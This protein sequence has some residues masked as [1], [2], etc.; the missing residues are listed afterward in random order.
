MLQMDRRIGENIREEAR[1]AKAIAVEMYRAGDLCGA[2]E[3]AVRA[4][5]LNPSLCGLLRLNAVLDVHMGLAKQINGEIDWY[6]VLSVDPTADL[7][8]IQQ[9]YQK[10]SLDIILDDCDNTVCSV[11]EANMFLTGSWN[12][13]CNEESKQVY[14]MRRQEQLQLQNLRRASEAFSNSVDNSTFWTLCRS[15]NMKYE[16]PGRCK[17]RRVMSVHCCKPFDAFECPGPSMNRVTPWT[18]DQQQLRRAVTSQVPSFTNN[19]VVLSAVPEPVLTSQRTFDQVNRVGQETVEARFEQPPPRVSGPVNQLRRAS[20][21]DN[22]R[23][24]PLLTNV[25]QFRRISEDAGLRDMIEKGKSLIEQTLERLVS[26][27]QQ[28]NVA[29]AS[30]S[31]ATNIPQGSKNCIA[32]E[33]VKCESKNTNVVV[34]KE[35][36]DAVF[37]IVPDTDFHNFDNDRTKASFREGNQVWAVYDD[38]G[39]PRLYAMVHGL[40]TQEPFKMCYSLL[41]SKNNE[42]LGPMKWIESGFY[43]TTGSFSIGKRDVWALY[44]NWSPSWNSSTPEEVVNKYQLVE[45]LHDFE[46]GVGVPVVPLFKVPGYK[47]VFR[48]HPYQWTIPK[49]ELFR[50]SHQVDSHFLTSEDGENVPVGFLELDPAYLTPELLNVVTKEEMR[51][52]ENVA[53]KKPKEEA[54]GGEAKKKLGMMRKL[55]TVVKK[56]KEEVDD[57]VGSSSNVANDGENS[58]VKLELECDKEEKL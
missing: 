48:R 37:V 33:G 19:P 49:C 26:A 25:P 11:D 3:F 51:G 27:S 31:A 5:R 2:K 20:G 32:A 41:Y 34:K 47:V 53:F 22:K 15:C 58:K 44:T 9:R 54:D 30:A 21:G 28:N 29:S 16:Y 13:L 10:L 23:K 18:Y 56:P 52:L 7:E 17:D 50:L 57:G 39:M 40:V 46:E 12:H 4:H 45:V 43:K 6:A 24:G 42:E 36:P 1:R 35:E 14:D 8:T 38:K 55:E